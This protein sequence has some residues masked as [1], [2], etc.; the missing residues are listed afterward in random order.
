M[1]V[2][3][4]PRHPTLRD[5]IFQS[6]LCAWWKSSREWWKR[7]EN[8]HKLTKKNKANQSPARLF[9]EHQL[10][11]ARKFGKRSFKCAV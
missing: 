2:K 1:K 10:Q 8:N 4:A 11:R 9:V 6:W 5:S 3:L 7:F